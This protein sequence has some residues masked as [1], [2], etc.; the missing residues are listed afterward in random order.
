MA[1]AV[2]AGIALSAS[3]AMIIANIELNSFMSRISCGAS[4]KIVWE[5][6]KVGNDLKRLT[7]PSGDH[8]CR[9]AGT[10]KIELRQGAR[11]IKRSKCRDP[12]RVGHELGLAVGSERGY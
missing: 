8:P 2:P 11:V 3:A 12:A 5:L 6:L 1:A 9:G 4:A 7:P 10:T